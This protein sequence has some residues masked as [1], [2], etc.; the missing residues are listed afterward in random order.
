MPSLS[1]YRLYYTVIVEVDVNDDNVIARCVEN[2][3]DEGQPQVPE[4]G[5]RGWRD[6]FYDLDT[7]EKVLD[8]LAYNL[9]FN[10]RSLS[11]LD[12]WADLPDTAA[13][14]EIMDLDLDDVVA[15]P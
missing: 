12:G 11:S 3:D 6:M 4:K 2:H 15:L 5:G 14:A 7:D 8:M 10:N 9:A 13:H 1:K